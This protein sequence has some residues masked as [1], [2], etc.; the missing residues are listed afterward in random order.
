MV[1]RLQIRSLRDFPD[2]YER[3]PESES[4]LS[5]LHHWREHSSTMME[6]YSKAQDQFMLVAQ[7]FEASWG[8]EHILYWAMTDQCSTIPHPLRSLRR[9]ELISV[10]WDAAVSSTFLGG[11][12]RLVAL[13]EYL[14]IQGKRYA[15]AL[16]PTPEGLWRLVKIP[17]D[18]PFGKNAV[19]LFTPRLD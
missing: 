16:D 3:W 19:C 10:G 5:S 13:G 14:L 15:A 6:V 4:I 17:Y 9:L 1:T 12:K 18:E 11:G 8:A 2:I 7:G